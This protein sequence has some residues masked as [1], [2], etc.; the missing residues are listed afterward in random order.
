[1]LECGE[2]LYKNN[3]DSQLS[4]HRV[5]IRRGCLNFISISPFRQFEQNCKP[6]IFA[7]FLEFVYRKCCTDRRTDRRIDRQRDRQEERWT[8]VQKY[9][10]RHII[11]L[12]TNERK[13]PF[14]PCGGNIMLSHCEVKSWRIAKHWVIRLCYSVKLF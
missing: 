9:R 7:V 4:R 14:T 6:V 10:C 13:R 2:S 1:M 5:V 3:T 8:L 11:L 12:N